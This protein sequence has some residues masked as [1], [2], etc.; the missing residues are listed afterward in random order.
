MKV[1]LKELNILDLNN[2][3]GDTKIVVKNKKNKLLYE[4]YLMPFA[5]IIM[6]DRQQS[7]FD[8][9]FSCGRTGDKLYKVL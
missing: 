4:G 8:F 3:K 9:M 2:L 5:V 1:K 7:L 6:R